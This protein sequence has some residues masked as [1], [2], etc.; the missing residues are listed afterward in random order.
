MAVSFTFCIISLF[1]AHDR[2]RFLHCA[3]L[4]ISSMTV[5]S[6]YIAYQNYHC[7]TSQCYVKPI[8]KRYKQLRGIAVRKQE[9]E[10]VKG[11]LFQNVVI[12]PESLSLPCQLTLQLLSPYQG[13]LSSYNQSSEKFRSG[14]PHCRQKQG[15]EKFRS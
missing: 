10:K 15:S 11:F 4:K 9:K 2:N 7:C 12:T 3:L 8:F 1:S 14:P 13:H 6:I 5:F